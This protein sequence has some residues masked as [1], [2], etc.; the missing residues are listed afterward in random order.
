M[1][2][3][4]IWADQNGTSKTQAVI[5]AIDLL[6]GDINEEPPLLFRI[7]QLTARVHLLNERVIKLEQE[8]LLLKKRSIQK[9]APPQDSF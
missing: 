5:R 8:K 7:D 6:V 2:R 4:N 1:S 9:Q 3:L